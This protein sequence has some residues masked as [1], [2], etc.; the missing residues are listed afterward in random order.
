MARAQFV[1]LAAVALLATGVAADADLCAKVSYCKEDSS[2]EKW[3]ESCGW[4]EVTKYK[5]EYECEEYTTE[6]GPEEEDKSKW[7]GWYWKDEKLEKMEE[8][9]VC[10]WNQ[11][12]VKESKKCEYGHYDCEDKE[13]YSCVDV[14]EPEKCWEEEKEECEWGICK[15]K[16]FEV[17]KPFPEETDCPKAKDKVCKKGYECV[18]KDVPFKVKEYVCKKKVVYTC[19]GSCGDKWCG[20]AEL[21]LWTKDCS[22]IEKL[23][24]IFFVVKKE[25]EEPAPAPKG[26]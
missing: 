16:I 14:E 18:E 19:G 13:V 5:T 1:I 22:F 4:E 11:K 26:W 9:L 21:C 15:T 24:K 23:K 3:V 6:C 17:C 20:K 7:G 2:C 12:C 8:K 10:G 25:K